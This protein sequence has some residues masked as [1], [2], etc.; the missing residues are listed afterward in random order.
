MVFKDFPE[1]RPGIELLQRSLARKRLAHAYLFS[2][3]ELERLEAVARALTQTLNCQK[4]V[5]ADGA[6]VDA[7]GTCTSCLRIEHDNHPDVHWVR[8]ESKTR[9]IKVEQVR[10]LIQEINL[11]PTEAEYKVGMIVAADRLR[12]EAANAFL[13]TLEE[14]PAKSILLLLSTEPQRLLETI[15]S[16]CLRLSFAGEGPPPL[17]PAK[18]EWLTAFAQMAA[19][20]Q[21][22]LLG[23]YLLLGGLTERLNQTKDAIEESLTARSPLH[24]YKEADKEVIER[25]EDELTAAVEAEYRRQ[26]ADLLSV[27]HWWLRDV[28]VHTL[29]A[30]LS[31]QE[32]GQMRSLLNFPGVAGTEAVAE[33]LSP[34][35]ALGNLEVIEQLQ[36][37]LS[38]NVQESLAL[39]VGLLKLRL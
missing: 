34:D 5:K 38:M 32:S 35:Q 11:K 22:T 8:P 31:R 36:G 20:S 10:D 12:T 19:G 25:W 23:R 2:G 37:W 14:P 29:A 30:S 39:E 4:P 16:R 27:L 1:P 13:K 18:K 6:A 28:W 33:R 15:V 21:Q 26:R 7:C 3:H 17:E 24:V 9:I